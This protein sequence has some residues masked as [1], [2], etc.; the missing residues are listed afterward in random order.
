MRA[1]ANWLKAVPELVDYPYLELNSPQNVT[2]SRTN[3]D[4]KNGVGTFEKIV[5]LLKKGDES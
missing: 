5:T 4:N 1:R 2:M 3:I